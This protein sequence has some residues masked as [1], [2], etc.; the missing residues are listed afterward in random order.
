MTSDVFVD[1]PSLGQTSDIDP[2]GLTV[3]KAF[4]SQSFGSQGKVE[5]HGNRSMVD[6]ATQHWRQDGLLFVPLLVPHTPL[7]FHPHL[8]HGSTCSQAFLPAA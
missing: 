2:F 1:L 3:S 5:L 8:L 4:G 6:R 7:I